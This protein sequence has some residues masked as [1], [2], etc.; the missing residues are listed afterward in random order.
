MSL[1]DN[2]PHECTILRKKTTRDSVGGSFNATPVTVQT[3]V[4]CW[5]QQASSRD[6]QEFKKRAISAD[7]KI[8]FNTDPAV[9]EQNQII[10]T[11]RNGVAVP[12]A[13]QVT[14][15]VMSSPLPDAGA[16]LGVVFRV[17]CN[18]TSGTE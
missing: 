10:I 7:R 6:M 11:K 15:D 9:N 17:M 18:T 3:G 4:A 8:F 14:L 2:L 5:E 13:S 12:A 1:L 16:G